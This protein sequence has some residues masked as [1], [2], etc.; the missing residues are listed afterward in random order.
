MQAD[1]STILFSA[2][3]VQL[4][5]SSKVGSWT[6]LTL[7]GNASAELPSRG[8]IKVEGTIHGFPFRAALEP[9]GQG[10]HWLKVSKALRDAADV[11]IGEMVTVEITRVEA[12]P[13][14]RAPIELRNALAAAPRAQ[15]LWAQITPLARRDWILWITSAR[16]PKTRLSRIEKACSMLASGK[17]RVCCFGGLNWLT[18]DHPSVEIWLPLASRKK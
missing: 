10:S 1:R 8:L 5:A 9:D 17:R 11:G 4:E 18:Q 14:V 13:E 16:Q 6:V 12:E 2:R 15:A 7:P 3:L